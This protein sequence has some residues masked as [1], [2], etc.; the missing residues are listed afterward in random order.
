MTHQL[1]GHS[2]DHG[3]IS[4]IGYGGSDGTIITCA[5][6]R[7]IKVHR[8]EKIPEGRRGGGSSTCLRA[9]ARCHEKDI[10]CADYHHKLGLIATG[11]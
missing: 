7:I 6:D 11:A 10:T 4:F 5:W 2:K 1:E 8:D 3:E 9:R